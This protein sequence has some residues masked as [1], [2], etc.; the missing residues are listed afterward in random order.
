ME[1]EQED[2]HQS[3][4]FDVQPS[5]AHI[6]NG[7][8]LQP[9]TPVHAWMDA[10]VRGLYKRLIFLARTYPGG[11]S[12]GRSKLKAAFRKAP[13]RPLEQALAK[14]A[15]HIIRQDSKSSITWPAL[16]QTDECSFSG[17]AMQPSLGVPCQSYGGRCMHAALIQVA[18]H[19]AW[20]QV[21]GY[22][23]DCCVHSRRM[24]RWVCTP[25]VRDT[26]LARST[27]PCTTQ[28]QEG[29][30]ACKAAAQQRP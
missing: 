10:Q 2:T 11:L 3:S 27:H 24:Q 26:V 30:H 9:R 7:F 19:V 20:Y 12:E 6:P 28:L 16:R 29:L 25:S 1:L 4:S 17:L 15:C 14:G 23:L 21:H 18:D 5:R 8:G 22:R 13:A